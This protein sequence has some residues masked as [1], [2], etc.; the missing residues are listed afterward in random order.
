MLLNI[1]PEVKIRTFLVLEKKGK[2][3]KDHC[4]GFHYMPVL[5]G[6]DYRTCLNLR[7]VASFFKI[8]SFF[9]AHWHIEDS[10]CFLNV[11]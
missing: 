1:F 5:R 9:F 10:S 8:C 11:Q 6:V 2:H 7:S 3:L 4:I